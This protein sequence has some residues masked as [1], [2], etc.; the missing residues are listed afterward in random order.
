MM[1]HA[2]I[3]L[4][5]LKIEIHPRTKVECKNLITID[6]CIHFTLRRVVISIVQLTFLSVSDCISLTVKVMLT[7]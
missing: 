3:Q 1:Y 6:V 5:C 2:P 7:S 4:G